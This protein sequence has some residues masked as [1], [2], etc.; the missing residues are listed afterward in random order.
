MN[1]EPLIEFELSRVD[2]S[3]VRDI[4]GP[5]THVPSSLREL[6]TARSSEDCEIAYWKLENVVVVQ[7]QLYEAAVY[8][9]PVLLA[10]I[11]VLECP[12]FVRTT[13]FELLFQIVHGDSHEEEV[14]RGFT[15]LGDRCREK[16]RHGLWLLFR[17]TKSC[18]REAAI[19]LLKTIEDDQSRLTFLEEN[20]ESPVFPEEND[21]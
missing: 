6:F 5:A 10:A 11:A 13:I 3:Q 18:H 2:W 17:E 15:D 8:V 21:K 14:L 4:T 20:Y 1:T 19:E 16:A 12:T 7:G 9:V